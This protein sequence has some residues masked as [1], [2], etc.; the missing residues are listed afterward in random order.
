[1]KVLPVSFTT[2]SSQ[3]KY[4][5]FNMS[6]LYTLQERKNKNYLPHYALSTA[7][8]ALTAVGVMLFNVSGKRRFP[9]S[10]A[11]LSDVTKGLNKLKNN[12][13]LVNDLKTDFVFPIKAHLLGDNSR[14]NNK[15][16]K[17]G[18]ILT[19]KNDEKLSS[20]LRALSEHFDE[21][22]IRTLSIPHE[23]TRLKEEKIISSKYNKNELYKLLK[24]AVDKA[25]NLYKEEK[26]ITVIDLG[27]IDDFTDLKIVKSQK[28][29]FEELINELSNNSNKGVV[30]IGTT[31]KPKSLPLF[32][33]YLPI[34][35]KKT[36]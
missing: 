30:W 11:E 14:I 29:N 28:S 32:F 4:D 3:N 6:Y 7:L 24:K 21:L 1:M 31:T 33:S 20:I 16:M 34:L 5:K 10:I 22:K 2:F 15:S 26:E 12:E 9:Y 23:S 36:N 35:I 17:L 8:A 25:Q 13:K 27:N 18:L 19:G